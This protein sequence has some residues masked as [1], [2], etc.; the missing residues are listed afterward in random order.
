MLEGHVSFGDADVLEQKGLGF[1]LDSW[2]RAGEKRPHKSRCFCPWSSVLMMETKGEVQ[3]KV[4]QT[5]P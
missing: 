1:W 4:Q 2:K 3:E 5:S